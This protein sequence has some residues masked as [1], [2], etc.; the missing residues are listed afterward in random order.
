[1]DVH[2]PI[3]HFLVVNLNNE[4]IEQARVNSIG[5]FDKTGELLTD[6][7]FVAVF[8]VSYDIDIRVFLE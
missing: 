6:V 2:N 5:G 4:T 8:S 7:C 3:K 1:M